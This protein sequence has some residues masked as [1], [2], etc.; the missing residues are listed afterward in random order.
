MVEDNKG[1]M[2]ARV[3]L[4]RVGTEAKARALRCAAR[5]GRCEVAQ[6]RGRARAR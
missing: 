6:S 2:K 1:L 5:E 3:S 4:G